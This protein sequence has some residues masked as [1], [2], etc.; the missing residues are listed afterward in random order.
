[1]RNFEIMSKNF[2]RSPFIALKVNPTWSNGCKGFIILYQEKEK[3]VLL[4]F[5]P[6]FSEGSL[7]SLWISQHNW[8]QNETEK[9]L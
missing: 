9:A 2:L 7:E 8:K 5:L 4:C 6:E 3:K 1:M